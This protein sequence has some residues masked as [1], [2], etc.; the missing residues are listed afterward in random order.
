M[1]IFRKVLKWFLYFLLIPISYLIIS[2]ILT[3]I[4]VNKTELNVENNKEVYL[5]TNGIHLNIII[6]INDLSSE[7]KDGLE[8]SKDEKYF[9][10]GWG[11]EN[12]YLNTPTW[13]DLTFGTTFNALFLK[14]STVIHLTKYKFKYNS[15]TKVILSNYELVRLNQFISKSF[16][17]DV[18]GNKII[19]PNSG[20]SNSDTFYRANGSYSC[21]RTCNSW[22]NEAFKESG[23]KSS[24]WTPFD[25]GLINKYEN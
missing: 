23:L 19:I 13:N 1:K 20:Y 10:F 8:F 2:L 11:D 5:S 24:L 4:T 14:S 21:F 17:T 9:S 15:W 7:L 22:V 25:F 3:F 18:N 6:S 16:K 12:F